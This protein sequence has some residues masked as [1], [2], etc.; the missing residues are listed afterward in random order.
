MAT[1][2]VYTDNIWSELMNPFARDATM[3][4]VIDAARA[5]N[6][7]IE[8]YRVC[9]NSDVNHLNQLVQVEEDREL[10]ASDKKQI[11]DLRRSIP[12]Q[13]NIQLKRWLKKIDSHT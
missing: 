9:V 6:N 2:V 10:V 12:D 8:R 3:Y 7:E 13:L 4:R 11:H 5:L 1:I